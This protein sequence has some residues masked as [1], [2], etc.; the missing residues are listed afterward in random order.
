L[1]ALSLSLLAPICVDPYCVKKFGCGRMIGGFACCSVV[2]GEA[3]ELLG[4]LPAGVVDAV[5]SDPPYSSGGQYRGDRAAPV[6]TRDVL[7]IVPAGGLVLDPFAGSGTTGVAAVEAGLHFLGFELSHKY[8]AA[9]A[10][11]VE[12]ALAATA[13][14][15]A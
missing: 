3:L 11:R 14:R 5:I 12:L 13:K 2:Q 4:R 1:A 6:A 10:A 9:G 15:A 7:R 8:S